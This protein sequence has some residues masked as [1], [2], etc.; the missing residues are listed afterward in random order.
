MPVG[1]LAALNS[2]LMSIG[3]SGMFC[4][5][6]T[7]CSVLASN[8]CLVFPGFAQELHDKDEVITEDE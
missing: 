4:D 1:G 6:L 7:L 8:L 5:R 2:L 3:E